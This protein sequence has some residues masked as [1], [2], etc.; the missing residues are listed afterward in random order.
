MVLNCR[1]DPPHLKRRQ[2]DTTSGS[3]RLIASSS[4]TAPSCIRSGSGQPWRRYRP[5]IRMTKRS[6]LKTSRSRARVSPEWI[7]RN[8]SR[9]SV[10]DRRGVHFRALAILA[11]SGDRIVSP[12]DLYVNRRT[13]CRP[14]QQFCVAAKISGGRKNCYNAH[15]CGEPDGKESDCQAAR[16]RPDT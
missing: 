13:A 10:A 15:N 5:A 4:P 11:G 8:R 6:W 12:K 3:K 16:F 9:S 7:F 1:A 14:D 2:P